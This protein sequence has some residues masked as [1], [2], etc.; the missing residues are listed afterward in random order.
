M[1][2]REE[3]NAV[4]R[5]REDYWQAMVINDWYMPEVK[6]G[7]C[8]RAWME[9]VRKGQFWCPKQTQL[10][11]HFM[12]AHPPTK[13][14]LANMLLEQVMALETS[15]DYTDTEWTKM[16]RTAE[17][18]V[19]RPPN[20]SW[21]INCLGF[22]NRMHPVFERD[23]KPDYK[24]RKQALAD[25]T[26]N[27]DDGFFNNLPKLEGSKLKHR[28]MPLPKQHQMDQK[29]AKLHVMR[30]ELEARIRQEEEEAQQLRSRHGGH[31]K[32][33]DVIA[34]ERNGKRDPPMAIRDPQNINREE[35]VRGQRFQNQQQHHN[36]QMPG[37]RND[38]AEEEKF[39]VGASWDD[40]PQRRQMDTTGRKPSKARKM[41][42]DEIMVDV[43]AFAV[44]PMSEKKRKNKSSIGKNEMAFLQQQ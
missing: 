12:I 28:G 7:M 36:E 5:T 13:E 6:Y 23:Y 17:L 20:A 30:D 31:P 21:I 3:A 33:I 8:S 11:R 32:L 26:F 34:P 27:N 43:N 19:A 14:V 41:K 38:N 35:Y 42:A 29:I 16:R 25:F 9:A 22:L 10:F 15:G 1:V 18:V 2:S 24:P 37:Q 44:E 39:S 4:V 40:I